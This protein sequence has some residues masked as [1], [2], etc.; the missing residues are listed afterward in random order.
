M[1]ALVRRTMLRIG[2]FG[3]FGNFGKFGHVAVVTTATLLAATTAV[4]ADEVRVA[5]AANFAAPMQRIAAE[6][7]KDSGHKAL[8]SV[9][10]TGKF[11]AQITQGAPFDVFLSADDET[12]ARLAAEGAALADSRY[13][14]AMGRLVLWSAQPGRVDAEGAVLRR[15]E[16]GHLALA[17]PKTAPYGAAAVEVMKAMGVLAA[18]S[19]KFVQGESIAQAHQFVASG[20]AEL[21]FVA[22]SQVWKDGRVADGSAWVV[23]ATLHG[24]IRQDAVLLTAA[25]DKPAALA[26]M[27]WLKGEKA[28]AVIR[29]FG[30]ELAAAP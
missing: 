28:R 3:K 14:Y 19:P 9:G 25:R 29:S 11:Y 16:F 10:A 22:L 21:G 5:V 26:L 1:H 30:Y 17:N 4:R 7:E 8:L 15:G 6:F 23:P 2:K 27:R 24:P 12:P 20:N 18:L 13:T